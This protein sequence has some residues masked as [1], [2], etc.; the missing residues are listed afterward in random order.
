MPEKLKERDFRL[1][2]R[3]QGDLPSERLLVILRRIYPE[4]IAQNLFQS[5]M[6]K[7]KKQDAHGEGTV[8][9]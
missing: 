1:K 4:E 9:G 3:K 7:E 6:T 5:M 2:P 8:S